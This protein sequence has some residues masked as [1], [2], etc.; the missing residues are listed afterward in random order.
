MDLPPVVFNTRRSDP[1]FMSG[2]F[3]VEETGDF[4]GLNDQKLAP[5]SRWNLIPE[6][7]QGEVSDRVLKRTDL[8]PRQLPCR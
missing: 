1:G 8:S 5:R 3:E 4:G 7:S 2:L 6:I